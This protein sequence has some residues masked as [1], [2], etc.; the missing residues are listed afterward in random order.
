MS[1]VSARRGSQSAPDPFNVHADLNLNPNRACSSTI[2]IVR[3]SPDH[4]Q[5]SPGHS[6]AHQTP[7]RL[8]F[9]FSS[10]AG[11]SS[12]PPSPGGSPTSSPRLR[13]SSF[14]S[15]LAAGKPR[16]TP[17]QIVD[18]AKQATST[19]SNVNAAPTST[20]AP[21]TF[22]PLPDDVYLPFLDRP[23]EVSALISS[24]PDVKLFTLLA[25]TFPPEGRSTAVAA[26]ATSTT[27]PSQSLISISLPPNPIHW[28]YPH[29]IYHLTKVDRSI[30][31]DFLWTVAARKCIFSH[32]ELIWERV[33]GALGVPPELDVDVEFVEGD[34]D[35]DDE[36]GQ[37]RNEDTEDWEQAILDSPICVKSPLRDRF[38]GGHDVGVEERTFDGEGEADEEERMISIEPLISSPP[39]AS[40]ST[41]SSAGGTL[42]LGLGD[43]AEGAED[44][45]EDEEVQAEIGEQANDEDPQVLIASK[46]QGLRISTSSLPA[47]TPPH[48]SSSPPPGESP[49]LRARSRTSSHSSLAG[50]FHRSESTGS[51]A[52]LWS[53]V[54][55]EGVFVSSSSVGG[56]SEAGFGG[57]GEDGASVEGMGPRF[58]ANFARLGRG[59]TTVVG[60]DAPARKKVRY[61]SSVLE[62]QE[63]AKK[64][65][66]FS[67]GHQIQMGLT[68]HERRRS[69]GAMRGG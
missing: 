1:R 17:D 50:P 49:R 13:P 68:E 34:G 15:T 24:P 16:L 60:G 22:T 69:W 12:G 54:R 43:I 35:A 6:K 18:L 58:P 40:T 53:A 10:F 19:A 5:R 4:H 30:A 3:V 20:T 66:A 44:E 52:A 46:I 11:P 28:T 41:L 48:T 14:L 56:G 8:S 67:H 63:E 51:L 42:G 37:E 57:A 55:Q 61:V 2:T 21:A 26:A 59:R 65:R 47:A 7:T 25:Q 64:V 45:D 36:V 32:S 38:D 27:D 9:A 31:P 39:P 62:G 23:A 29:L 33:K